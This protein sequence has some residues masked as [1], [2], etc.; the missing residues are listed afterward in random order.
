M[1]E[2]FFGRTAVSVYWDRADK[3]VR[4][5][6]TGKDLPHYEGLCLVYRD[7]EGPTLVNTFLSNGERLWDS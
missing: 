6:K 4:D 2:H 1:S 7:V 5:L 3:V